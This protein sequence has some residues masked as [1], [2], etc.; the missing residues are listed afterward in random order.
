[1]AAFKKTKQNGACHI[2]TISQ[3]HM[4]DIHALGQTL[5]TRRAKTR[6]L[7]QF[8]TRA[9]VA[10]ILRDNRE[11]GVEVLLIKR[12][13]IKGDR[14]SG[15][16]A[17]PGGKMQ[18][19]D[20]SA[21]MAAIRETFEEVGL[22]LW[23]KDYRGRLSDVMTLAHGLKK[24]M[25]VSPYVFALSGSGKIQTNYEV[26]ETVWIPLAALV[27][28]QNRSTILWQNYGMN[29]VLPCCLYRGYQIWGLTL[30]MLDDLISAW[31]S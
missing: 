10:V 24:P 14:W 18:K 23:R 12:A 20:H 29:K 25:V 5:R 11:H 27:A 9:A 4:K 1:M 22:L 3:N 17:L 15:H 8:M 2:G 16:M 19:S 28:P 30:M 6:L 26:A 7:R 31:Q 21:R 13:H